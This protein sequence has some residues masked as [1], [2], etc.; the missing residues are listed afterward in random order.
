MS[1]SSAKSRLFTTLKR[2]RNT[3][4]TSPNIDE[5]A[6]AG[7]FSLNNDQLIN[8][9]VNMGEDNSTRDFPLNYN[10]HPSYNAPSANNSGSDGSTGMS[11]EV[12]RGA[13]RTG[14]TPDQSLS[15]NP[16]FSF[17]N[18]SEYQL[19]YTPGGPEDPRMVAPRQGS[20]LSSNLLK[21][22]SVRK[23]N[24]ALKPSGALR[25]DAGAKQREFSPAVDKMTAQSNMTGQ[26]NITGQSDMTLEVEEYEEATATF[27]SRN[28]RFTRSTYQAAPT[29]L[30]GAHVAKT[31]PSRPAVNNATAQAA[32]YTAN[33]FMLPDLP[34]ITE[35][36]SEV[37]ANGSALNRSSPNGTVLHHVSA[38]PRTQMVTPSLPSQHSG[39]DNVPVTYDDKAILASLQCLQQR[40]AELEME[41]LET[42]RQAEEYEN[43]IIDLQSQLAAERR[44][45]DSAHGSDIEESRINK[46]RMEKTRLQAS[47]TAAHDKLIRAKSQ[48]SLSEAS[49]KEAMRE[50]EELEMEVKTLTLWREQLE[51]MVQKLKKEKE[52]LG[53]TV[54]RTLKQKEDAEE[55]VKGLEVK[56]EGARSDNSELRAENE[57]FRQG[58]AKLQ[59][60]HEDAKAA[61]ASLRSQVTGLMRVVEDMEAQKVGKMQQAG[62]Q[63]EAQRVRNREER[64]QQKA[65]RALSKEERRQE[66]NKKVQDFTCD[67]FRTKDLDL[68]RDSSRTKDPSIVISGPPPRSRKEPRAAAV[69][70]A[71]MKTHDVFKDMHLPGPVKET[72]HENENADF[73]VLSE[74]SPEEEAELRKKIE[75]EHMARRKSRKS[76]ASQIVHDDTV[77]PG[78]SWISQ[79][80]M[81]ATEQQRQFEDLHVSQP[82]E[83]EVAALLDDTL[84]GLPSYRSATDVAELRQKIEEEHMARRK[85]N[86][87]APETRG[88]DTLHSNGSG[89]LPR[90]SSLRDVNAKGDDGTGRLSLLGLGNTDP[91]R[92]TKKVVVQSPHT[93]DGSV[94]PHQP[95]E[96]GDLSFL[97]NTSRRRHR[98]SASEEGMTSAFIVP[99]ITFHGSGPLPTTTELS[100]TCIH[101]NAASCTVCDPGNADITIPV[102]VPVTDREVPEDPDVTS[103]TIRP[104]Q[105]PPVALA[106][107]I[108]NLEDEITHLKLQLHT[109]QERYN[110]HNPALSQRQRLITH[111]RMQRLTAEIELRSV[112]V[113]N[114]YDVLEGQK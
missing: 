8:S 48:N 114:L 5:Y 101:H 108:K 43:D 34:N 13:K 83:D 31:T 59:E 40:V 90:K 57:H 76:Q 86:N 93:S 19:M 53:L 95:D 100:K 18:D 7:S 109:Q 94:L 107:V 17:G 49:A 23:A 35:L 99:D 60:K 78:D 69:R 55:D 103:A 85:R 1:H 111:S 4:P 3:S 47:L 9:T 56:L 12:G 37:R 97:S 70:E 42:S 2:S 80:P 110:K 28:T 75:E 51:P 46:A 98:R 92:A 68:A 50:R 104:S 77:Q 14:G 22:A 20:R 81:N 65:M 89:M 32:I 63:L 112:Q 27:S 73:T 45:P 39:V 21:Q 38:K 96:T 105:P 25:R 16:V 10:E 72:A 74:F 61:N 71:S 15:G 36:V 41:K 87:S 64:H 79:K 54:L 113:Y 29:R 102:P 67:S 33:S 82:N 11:I 106:K 52:N 58:Y 91:L 24:G 26:T 30:S 88:D 66:S 84:D 44:R 62:I 6:T